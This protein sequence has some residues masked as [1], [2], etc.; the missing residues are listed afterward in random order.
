VAV[1]DEV[2]VEGV[3][4]VLLPRH[5]EGDISVYRN[6]TR[7]KVMYFSES[8]CFAVLTFLYK[9]SACLTKA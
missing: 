3:E 1:V 2:E 6:L 7:S 5:E 9:N 4:V 8:F